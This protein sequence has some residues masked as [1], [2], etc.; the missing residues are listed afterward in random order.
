M[1]FSSDWG[2][3]SILQKLTFYVAMKYMVIIFFN[4]VIL[5]LFGS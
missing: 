2:L 1:S 5:T 3:D 4:T